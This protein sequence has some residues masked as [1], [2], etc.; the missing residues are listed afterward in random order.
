[1]INVYNIHNSSYYLK[2][3]VWYSDIPFLIEKQYA[4]VVLMYPD[5]I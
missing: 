5:I 4:C 1:M 2:Q 3:Y